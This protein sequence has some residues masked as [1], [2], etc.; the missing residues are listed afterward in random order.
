MTKTIV[1]QVTHPMHEDGKIE[2]FQFFWAYYVD[3]YRS[4]THCQPC[5][6][7]AAIPEFNS[8]SLRVGKSVPLDKMD[9]HQ[10]VYVCGVGAGLKNERYRK[11][12]HLPLRYDEGRSVSAIT[13]NGYVVTAVNAVLLQIPALPQDWAPSGEVLPR[14]MTRCK[15]FQFAVEVFGFPSPPSESEPQLHL[16]ALTN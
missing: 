3:G 13:Y 2:G 1:L 16:P 6:K 15:N 14:E 11:N 5:F 8:S 9:K 4:D 10:Y 12:F 7:G